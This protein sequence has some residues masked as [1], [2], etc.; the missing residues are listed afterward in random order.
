MSK[1]CD[2]EGEKKQKNN[3][4]EAKKQAKLSA[5]MRIVWVQYT[6][7]GRINLAA[8]KSG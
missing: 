4:K 6:A 7:D 8:I 5:I 2:R 3:K 1:K